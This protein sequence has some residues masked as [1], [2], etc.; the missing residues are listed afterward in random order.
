MAING[1]YFVASGGTLVTTWS[2]LVRN[3]SPCVLRLADGTRGVFEPGNPLVTGLKLGAP[4]PADVQPHHF[5]PITVLEGTLGGQSRRRKGIVS[6][7]KAKATRTK[8]TGDKLVAAQERAA[9]ARASK[10]TKTVAGP[11]G[12]LSAVD[13]AIVL[14]KAGFTAKEVLAA[15]AV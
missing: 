13:Q 3:A 8:P 4:R 15:L 10:A 6:D 14:R 1:R 5:E 2:A 11:S 7:A 12:A 9:H